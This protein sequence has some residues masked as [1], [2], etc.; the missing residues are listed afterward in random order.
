M[1]PG[2]SSLHRINTSYMQPCF[3]G[4]SR[5]HADHCNDIRDQIR[6]NYLR[7]TCSPSIHAHFI[8]YI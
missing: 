2:I 8:F 6:R 4:I 1:L 3:T 5:L 7:N